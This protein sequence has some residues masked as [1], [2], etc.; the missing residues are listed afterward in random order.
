MLKTPIKWAFWSGEAGRKRWGFPQKISPKSGEN[1]KN[2]FLL[3][4]LELQKN[5]IICEKEKGG[6]MK[7]EEKKK[8]RKIYSV[9]LPEQLIS[10]IDDF[11]KKNGLVK[12]RLIEKAIRNEIERMKGILG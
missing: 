7:S 3:F 10:E 11:C 2:V 9:R 5:A 1:G 8:K 6:A 12:S 4:T